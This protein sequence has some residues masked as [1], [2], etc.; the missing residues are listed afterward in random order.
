MFLFQGFLGSGR[1]RSPSSFSGGTRQYVI[2]QGSYNSCG[3]RTGSNLTMTRKTQ[4]LREGQP[5]GFPLFAG[6]VLI[7]SRT[8]S[9][10]FLWVIIIGLGRGKRLI[11]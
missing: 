3:Q 8:L 9:G 10:R 6:E 2:S 5:G 11:L 1:D 4:E 7:V